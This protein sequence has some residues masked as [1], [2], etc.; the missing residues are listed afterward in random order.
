MEKI[1]QKKLMDKSCSLHISYIEM[2]ALLDNTETPNNSP[3]TFAY[4]ARFS[5][6][7]FNSFRVA[8]IKIQ[9][10]GDFSAY[11]LG[12]DSGYFASAGVFSG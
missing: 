10:S 7:P 4:R 9:L 12:V 3:N 2:S 11:F 1:P 6:I 5:F 8:Q